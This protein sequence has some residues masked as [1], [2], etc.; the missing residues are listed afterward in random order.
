MAPT[1]ALEIAVRGF[2]EQRRIAVAGVSRSKNEAANFIFRKLRDC[3]YQAF[4]VNPK[5]DRAEGAVCYPTLASI[6]GGVDAVVVA[7]PPSAAP[8]L[9]RQG[10][11]LGI[12]WVWMHRSFG[13]GS[14]SDEAV[15]L[16][17]ENGIRVIPGGCPMM[18]CSPVDL[19]HRCMRW[20]LRL[21]G[22]LPTAA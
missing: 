6:P 20:V 16:C 9:V 13:Q 4:A 14:V 1:N 21:T 15:A 2:L 19:P 10:V 8:E 17:L 22:G 18:F 11:A 12:G 7:T 5:T 3:G